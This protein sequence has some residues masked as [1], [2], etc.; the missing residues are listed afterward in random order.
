MREGLELGL[1][2]VHGIDKL[3][4]GGLVAWAG[5]AGLFTFMVV[6]IGYAA[7]D[8]PPWTD[9]W[10]EF[11]QTGGFLAVSFIGL[12]IWM[13]LR[14]AFARM[15]LRGR[16]CLAGGSWLI[17]AGGMVFFGWLVSNW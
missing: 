6:F 13:K 16:W 5:V 3:W 1:R 8:M 2:A 9:F 10:I 17:C 12:V 4:V 7:F 11:A 15:N 14:R